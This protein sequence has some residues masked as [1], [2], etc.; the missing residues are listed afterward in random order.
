MKLFHKKI[1]WAVII[2]ALAIALLCPIALNY[3]LLIPLNANIVGNSTHWLSF[4]GGYLGAIISSTVAFIILYV[5]YKNN[6]KENENN[7]QLQVSV[8]LYQQESL[9][10]NNLREAMI[11]NLKWYHTNH[12]ID[13]DNS[14]SK[15]N[16]V[17]QTINQIGELID[18]LINSDTLVRTMMPKCDNRIQ[19]NRYNEK[20]NSS[21]N[22]YMDVLLDLQI[23]T[24]IICNKL[25]KTNLD[26]AAINWRNAASKEL[27]DYIEQS[28]DDLTINIDVFLNNRIESCNDLFEELRTTIIDCLSAEQKRIDSIVNSNI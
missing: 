11:N 14:I 24:S 28:N 22:K 15:N 18:N 27:L 19:L 2:G 16:D 17:Y 13:V 25:H 21:Y 8:L 5:Q 3:I 10:L 6:S 12:L 9:W 20:R 1:K 26:K 7:R 4:W 23:I